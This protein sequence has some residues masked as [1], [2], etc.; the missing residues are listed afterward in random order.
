MGK[1]GKEGIRLLRSPET[2]KCYFISCGTTIQ[3]GVGRCGSLG[4]V[5]PVKPRS[6]MLCK[7]DPIWSIILRNDTQ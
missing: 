3:A 7:Y 1:G 2:E 6:Q 5:G 4:V